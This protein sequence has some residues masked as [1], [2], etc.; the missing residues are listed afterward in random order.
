MNID[1]DAATKVERQAPIMS[2][3]HPQ[4]KGDFPMTEVEPGVYKLEHQWLSGQEYDIWLPP[5]Q[6]DSTTRQSILGFQSKIA[7]LT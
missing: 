4:A 1:L 7:Y 5:A 6:A 2:S 3:T